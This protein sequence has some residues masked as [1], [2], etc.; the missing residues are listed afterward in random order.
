MTKAELLEECINNKHLAE[1]VGVKDQEIADLKR[2]HRDEIKELRKL[3][4]DAKSAG[5]LKLKEV[6]EKNQ[7]DLNAIMKLHDEALVKHKQVAL[8]YRNQRD[9]VM[10]AHGAL[11]KTIQGTLD[12]SLDLNSYMAREFNL[13]KEE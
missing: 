1:A 7:K 8:M 5:D 10:F 13:N 6:M 2:Q 4:Q 9:H 3:P 11:L 12:N